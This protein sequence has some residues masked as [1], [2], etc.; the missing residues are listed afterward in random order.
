MR[1]IF[2]IVYKIVVGLVAFVLLALLGLIIINQIL[3]YKPANCEK[4]YETGVNRLNNIEKNTLLLI[5]WN[6]G[7]A[8]LGKEMDFFYEGGKTVRPDPN[9]A[10]LYMAGILNTLERIEPVDFVLLQEVDVFSKRG[11]FTNQVEHISRLL[12]N[13]NTT[14]AKN[15]DVWYVPVPVYAPMGRVESGMVV[16]SLYHS[17]EAFR[18]SFP[19]DA[20]WPKRLFFFSRCYI[21]SRYKVGDKDLV[22]I[23]THNSAYD[24]S[25]AAKRVQMEMLKKCML[26]EYQKGNY[27]ISGGDWNINPSGF[28]PVQ[29]TTGD[30]MKIIPPV[31][32]K[33]FFPE[34]WKWAYDST[35]PTNRD[36]STSYYKGKTKTTII[37]YFI[38]SP[39]V[40]IIEVN[41]I[42]T[43]FKFSDHQPVYLKIGL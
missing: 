39:N 2:Q 22:I 6:I 28:N 14:F 29:I 11:Y 35:T 5:T 36:V 16:F 12:G 9:T 32:E 8:G 21:L 26:D 18:Y 15:Y 31:T 23:N 33:D 7:Y 27:V 19:P 38:V 1:S 4:L 43:E 20:A 13:Y 34:G 17:T 25:G 24:E 3:F 41:T 37:D 30:V 40:D 42:Q 10:E